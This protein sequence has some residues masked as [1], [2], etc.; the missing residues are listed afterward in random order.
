[1]LY[2]EDALGDER[3]LQPRIGDV[4]GSQAELYR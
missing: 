3:R 1:M 4:Q 2:V